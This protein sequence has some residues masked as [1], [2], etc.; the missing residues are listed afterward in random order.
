VSTPPPPSSSD[1]TP[2]PDQP[3]P[4][5]PPESGD[6][7][8]DGDDAGQE[9]GRKGRRYN[10][11]VAQLHTAQQE[12]DDA[13]ARLVA[14]HHR[15]V[16]RL[17]AAS[18]SQPTDVWLDGVGLDGLLGDDGQVDE[19]KVTAAVTALVAKRPGLQRPPRPSPLPGGGARPA[20]GTP[21]GL[22]SVLTRL[23]RP[24]ER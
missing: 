6:G 1:P 19:A 12:R 21:A 15:E 8:G 18:L 9:G 2:P 22:A 23:G 7:G 17:A 10:D 20:G 3:P 14:I 13:R 24:P 16:E 4:P 11:I 5:A